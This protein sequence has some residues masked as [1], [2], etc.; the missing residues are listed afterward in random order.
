MNRPVFDELADQKNR[1]VLLVLTGPTGAGKDTILDQILAVH[2]NAVKIVTTTTRAPRPLETEGHP[3]HFVSRREFEHKIG[4]NEFFEWVEFR[5]ELYGTTKEALQNALDT[6]KDVVWR[7]DMKGVKNIKEKARTMTDRVV[8]V[9]I[10]APSM[11]ILE[12]RVKKAENGESGRW[13]PDI[14]MWELH[15]Y[16]DCDYL[17]ENDNLDHAVK[18]I[19]DIMES[20]RSEIIHST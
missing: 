16:D 6:N 3:Y 17:V 19:L 5:G 11:E 9:F 8:F 15:Q 2:S 14:V 18:L 12:E 1:G 4:Q 20:K 10:T 7:I 13:N